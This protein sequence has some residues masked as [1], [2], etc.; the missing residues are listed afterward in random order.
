[1]KVS[2]AFLILILSTSAW[3]QFGFLSG[4]SS[5]TAGA[6]QLD[7]K[8]KLIRQKVK[9]KSYPGGFEE[10]PL[11]VQLQINAVNRKMSPVQEAVEEPAAPGESAHD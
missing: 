1:M 3:A 4:S 2:F 10:E 7:E 8:E 9:L 5:S 6:E 11:R